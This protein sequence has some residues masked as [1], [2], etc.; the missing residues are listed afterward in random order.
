MTAQVLDTIAIEGAHHFL[1]QL[2]PILPPGFADSI[3]LEIG[4]E[5]TANYRG[6][7]AHWEIQDGR[8]YLAELTVFGRLRADAPAKRVKECVDVEDVKAW[9][10]QQELQAMGR[11][12]GFQEL[13]GTEPPLFAAWVSHKLVAVCTVDDSQYCRE[14]FGVTG[15][16]T[17]IIGVENGVVIS[18]EIITNPTWNPERGERRRREAEREVATKAAIEFAKKR[19]S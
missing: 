11:W 15:A 12:I 5:S 16:Q 9:Y 13:F 6:W 14:D 10:R 7:R 1:A 4:H 17:R 8:L 19:N 18:D 2:V 3:G